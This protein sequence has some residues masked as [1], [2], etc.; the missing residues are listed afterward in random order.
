[1]NPTDTP[2]R[3]RK[4]TLS[5]YSMQYKEY[6]C[7]C[8]KTI[9][10]EKTTADDRNKIKIASRLN[11][12]DSKHKLWHSIAKNVLGSGLIGSDL[13]DK[14]DRF[15]KKHPSIIATGVDDDHFCNSAVY[16]IPHENESEIWGVTVLYIPQCTGEKPI[17]FFLYPDHLRGQIYA[18]NEIAKR[19][20]AKGN[21]RLSS[22]WYYLNRP[23][24]IADQSIKKPKAVNSIRPEIV[25]TEAQKRKRAASTQ[26]LLASMEEAKKESQEK[27]Y[28]DFV[29]KFKELPPELQARLIE[30]NK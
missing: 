4:L 21:T 3:C 1:M 12:S 29:R 22:L 24:V 11:N 13:I 15:V 16:Y 8:R 2:C 5:S 30:E 19:M 10:F 26:K 9:H 25:E 20:R 28:Q 6:R 23:P 18:I 7:G 14:M 27:N 17:S